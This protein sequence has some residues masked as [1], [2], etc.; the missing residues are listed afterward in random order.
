MSLLRHAP[1]FDPAAAAGL[2]RRL[3]DFDATAS[4][5]PSERD[6]NF[7]LTSASGDRRVLKIAN[8]TDERP[9]IDA[10]TAAMAH[11]AA[12]TGLCPRVL[13]APGGGTIA[14]CEGQDGA[15]HLVRLVT[16][17]PGTPLGSVR[18]HSPGLLESL[19]R[20]LGA[21]DAA[22]DTFDHPA[23]HRDFHWDIVRALPTIA[24]HA[25]RIADRA[26][27]SAVER[28]S[29]GA[30][31]ITGRLMPA[32]RRS[33]IHGDANDFNVIVAPGSDGGFDLVD[34]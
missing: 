2:A 11:V 1:V 19:G 5:L 4:P 25:P 31:A 18:R 12:Q 3:Y 14:E 27:R 9:L 20:S 7:L 13:P 29:E 16:W 8:A 21:M 33:A 22:L 26:L 34:D 32:L 17:I 6:Q 24:A 23:I 30:V 15:R 28:I 10:Q